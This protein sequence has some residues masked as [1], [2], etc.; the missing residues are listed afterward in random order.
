MCPPPVLAWA[1]Q[2][3]GP[4]AVVPAPGVCLAVTVLECVWAVGK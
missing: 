2:I 1:E 4:L 3:L